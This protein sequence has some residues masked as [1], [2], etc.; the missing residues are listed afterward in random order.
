VGRLTALALAALFVL[1]SCS[2]GRYGPWVRNDGSIIESSLLVEFQGFRDCDQLDVTFM[3][4]FGN[5]Y[6]RDPEMVLG[7]VTAPDGSG[8]VLEYDV[9]FGDEVLTDLESQGFTHTARPIGSNVWV[10]REI[11]LDPAGHEDFIYV[12]VD[13]EAIERWVRYEDTCE[14]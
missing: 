13:G 2:D 14:R 1:T 4:F 6:A 9:L 8:R 12:V 10:E 7:E 3:R 11:Y 5:Q